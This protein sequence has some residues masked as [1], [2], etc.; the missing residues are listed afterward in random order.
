MVCVIVYVTMYSVWCVGGG[1]PCKISESLLDS[2][3]Y[4]SHMIVHTLNTIICL[5]LLSYIA[6]IKTVGSMLT[7]E[8]INIITEHALI[9]NMLLC[10]SLWIILH[11]HGGC[12]HPCRCTCN[13]KETCMCLLSPDWLHVYGRRLQ[14]CTTIT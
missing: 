3:T 1:L 11:V 4:E 6:T 14:S 10:N 5:S 8:H 13:Q 2:C 12:C 9:H 7:L